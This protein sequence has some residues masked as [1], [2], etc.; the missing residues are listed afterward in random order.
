MDFR[1]P[2]VLDAAL[3]ELGE[4]NG[5]TEEEVTQALLGTGRGGPT[6]Q[7][8]LGFDHNYALN[9]FE[10]GVTREI[11]KVTHDESGRYMRVYSSTPGVQL[12]T[13]NYIG[14]IAGK[15]GALYQQR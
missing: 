13:S 7:P 6:G 11:A 15:A 8:P 3:A 4:A 14:N 1:Q 9:D 2:K 12:Y 10:P 5:Y